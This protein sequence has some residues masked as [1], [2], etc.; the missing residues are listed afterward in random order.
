MGGLHFNVRLSPNGLHEIHYTDEPSREGVKPCANYL[1]ESLANSKFSDILCV[2]MTGM[3]ADGTEGILNL[4]NENANP[5]NIN[6]GKNI[7]VISQNQSSCVVYGMPKSVVQ[8]GLSD[9]ELDLDD[10]AGKMTEW[11]GRH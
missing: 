6:K 7:A 11:V 1:Y 3:G 9:E 2:V 8:A 10:L 4:K 5:S